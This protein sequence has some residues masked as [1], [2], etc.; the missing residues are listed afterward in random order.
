VYLCINTVAISKPLI[1]TTFL[2]REMSGESLSVI[3]YTCY[4][5]HYIN[6]GILCPK[7]NDVH[8]ISEDIFDS[9]V[10]TL[11]SHIHIQILSP[12]TEWKQC[13]ETKDFSLVHGL[14][15]TCTSMWHSRT[16]LYVLTHNIGYWLWYKFPSFS[17]KFYDCSRGL[18]M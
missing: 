9:L 4:I 15:C 13:A 6:K 11:T 14:V 16:D 18:G 3:D 10:K 17:R 2:I 8:H 1:S 5:P 12:F 7:S